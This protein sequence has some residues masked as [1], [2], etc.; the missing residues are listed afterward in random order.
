[1]SLMDLLLQEPSV[2]DQFSQIQGFLGG[3]AGQTMPSR[4]MAGPVGGSGGS[5]SHWE[6]VA[7][8]M[9]TNKYGY[10]PDQFHDLDSIISGGQGSSGESSWDPNAVNPNGG[11]YGIPQILPSAH[12]DVNLQDDPRGQ[13]RWLLNYV[14]DRYGG[15]SQALDFKVQNGWY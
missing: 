2:S 8:R 5:P 10:T 7:Q 4:G 3:G 1:M 11:A 15:P 14:Q 9:A 13:I 12:P 6:N